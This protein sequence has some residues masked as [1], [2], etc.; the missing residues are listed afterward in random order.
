MI[1]KNQSVFHYI[2]IPASFTMEIRQ[3]ENKSS[4]CNGDSKQKSFGSH[5]SSWS[6]HPTSLVLFSSV[7]FWVIKYSPSL[8][9]QIPKGPTWCFFPLLISRF[10]PQMS[11]HI[12]FFL[13]SWPLSQIR[14]Y[15]FLSFLL[16]LRWPLFPLPL[17]KAAFLSFSTH[18]ILL[19]EVC[20]HSE[21]R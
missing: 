9:L 19:W 18:S 15:L 7:L 14:A 1:V 6:S 4:V 8:V 5:H 16:L 2:I 12:L 3:R 17:L 11:R 21:K 20:R 13:L 10:F